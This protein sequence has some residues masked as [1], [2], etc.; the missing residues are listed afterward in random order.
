MEQAQGHMQ[1]FHQLSITGKYE[2]NELDFFSFK[3]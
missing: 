1:G 2:F 3:L